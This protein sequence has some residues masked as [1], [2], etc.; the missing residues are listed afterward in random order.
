ML[1]SLLSFC[2]V[3][4]VYVIAAFLIK[5]HEYKLKVW[6]KTDNRQHFLIAFSL[7]LAVAHLWMQLTCEKVWERNDTRYLC[8]FSGKIALWIF[9]A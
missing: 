9:I 3:G 7:A 2:L 6:H 1:Y 5:V 4:T 8:F